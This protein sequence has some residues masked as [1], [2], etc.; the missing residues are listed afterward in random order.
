MSL[1]AGLLASVARGA[2]RGVASP[3]GL[4]ERCGTAALGGAE[5][6]AGTRTAEGGGATG[7]LVMIPVARP[8]ASEGPS[9]ES[10]APE[11]AKPAANDSPPEVTSHA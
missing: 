7:P 10:P 6:H 5:R 9:A 8:A 3:K 11:A 2:E 1:A 4:S